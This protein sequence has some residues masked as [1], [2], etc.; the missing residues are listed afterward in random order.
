MHQTFV[1]V[2]DISDARPPGILRRAVLKKTKATFSRLD[3]QNG[4]WTPRHPPKL[5]LKTQKNHLCQARNF[6]I[7]SARS[8][9][10]GSRLPVKRAS[11]IKSRHSVRSQGCPLYPQKRT[12]IE[13]VW[14]SALCQ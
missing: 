6:F 3:R 2:R 5:K 9:S 10:A 13:R 1:L 11:A 14:M 8:S 4:I 12:L 7:F